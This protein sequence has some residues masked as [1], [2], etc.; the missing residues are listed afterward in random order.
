MRQIVHACLLA[1][2]AL[3]AR[4]QV[5][6]PRL[7]PD[8]GPNVTIFDPTMSAA[9]IQATLDSAFLSQEKSEFGPRRLAFLFKPGTYHVDTRVGFY[10]QLSGLGLS[11][12]DVLIDGGVR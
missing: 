6:R 9:A 1:C 8:F 11:P 5:V 10:T 7:D 12:D 4:S 2:L 3:P